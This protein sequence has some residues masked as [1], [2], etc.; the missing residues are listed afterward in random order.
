[1]AV[2][3]VTQLNWNDPFFWASISETSG[4]HKLDL[5]TLPSN[6]DVSADKATGTVTLTDGATTFTVGEAGYGGSS[7]ATL[8]GGTGT[9]LYNIV[10]ALR[11]LSTIGIGS[12]TITRS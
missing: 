8:G 5:S 12:E 6:F 10:I 2:V 9:T 1:M 4:G 11:L 3:T 7:D